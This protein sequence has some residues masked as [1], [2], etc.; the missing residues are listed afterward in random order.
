[1]SLQVQNAS[2]DVVAGAGVTYD[3]TGE[4]GSPLSHLTLGVPLQPGQYHIDVQW[5]SGFTP[6]NQ[7]H[8]SLLPCP[9]LT[10]GSALPRDW[11]V[12]YQAETDG[13][14][15]ATATLKQPQSFMYKFDDPGR[16]NP[17]TSPYVNGPLT[18]S[19]VSGTSASAV[20]PPAA[21]VVPNGVVT[22]TVWC[23]SQTLV[24]PVARGSY[25]C[26]A[27]DQKNVDPDAA[28]SPVVFV[29][30][31]LAQPQPSVA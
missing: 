9:G 4:R 30:V 6:W 20:A 5:W 26:A 3:V 22:S 23:G 8:A 24:L 27:G 18:F 29:P 13:W 11:N 28:K 1:M 21:G 14:C 2:L 31:G 16:N 19:L 25:Y 15:V 7:A 10:F 12:A 17:S